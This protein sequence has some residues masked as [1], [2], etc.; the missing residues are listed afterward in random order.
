MNCRRGRPG[1]EFSI[2][3]ASTERSLQEIN[4]IGSLRRER[5]HFCVVRAHSF[6]RK[7][8][9]FEYDIELLVGNFCLNG[10]ERHSDDPT[11]VESHL[12]EYGIAVGRQRPFDLDEQRPGGISKW[13]AFRARIQVS[14]T[15][16]GVKILRRLRR[17]NF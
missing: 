10:M 5:F 11:A 4:K 8:N 16:V 13:P 14:E 9:A 3:G 15:V 7:R 17:P 6:W 1:I 12:D 2:A